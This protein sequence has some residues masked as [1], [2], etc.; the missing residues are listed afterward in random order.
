MKRVAAGF[1]LLEMLLAIS[2]L[3]LLVALAYGTLR[4]GIRGW[5]AASNEADQGDALR[6]SWPFLHQSLEAAQ[7]EPDPLGRS[8]RFDGTAKALTWVGELPAHFS[9]GGPQLLT[10][11]VQRDE[12]NERRRQLV[13]SSQALDIPAGTAITPQKA[14]LVDDL[15]G[16]AIDY[17][18]ASGT[19]N[20]SWRSA[21]QT[22]RVLPQLI[23][24]RVTPRHKMAWPLLM[25][26]PYLAVPPSGTSQSANNLDTSD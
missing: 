1:T 26:H 20:P 5:E 12:K 11:S 19:G 4:L 21:W 23:R 6:V 2:L 18:G 25:A 8:I 16:L 17:Y 14:I 9:S 13:L 10:L 22:Q 3:T 15:A 24:V 7:A